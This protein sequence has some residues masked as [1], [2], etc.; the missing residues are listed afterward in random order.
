MYRRDYSDLEDQIIGTVKSA[1]DAIDKIDFV[2]LK[3][4]FTDKTEDTFTEV[5]D[6]FKIYTEKIESKYRE[7]NKRKN[8]DIAKYIMKKP[9]GNVS[10][11]IYIIFGGLGTFI[12]G[13]VSFILLISM[14]FV[15]LIKGVYISFLL[16]S[17]FLLA[18]LI[19][20]FRGM[21]LRKR[22]A[23]FKKYV[24]FMGEK[25]YIKIQELAKLIREKEEFVVKDL[26]KMIDLG[27]FLEGH[28]DDEKTYFMLNDEVYNDY[29]NLKKQMSLKENSEKN[30]EE[31]KVEDQVEN[32]ITIGREYISQIRNIKNSIYRDELSEKLNK[33]ENVAT[34]ILNYVEKNPN[35][36]QDVNKFINHYLPI[37]IKLITSYKELSIQIVQGENIKNAKSEIRKSIDLINTAFE[38]L[39]DDLYEDTVLDISTDI[40]VLKTL[41]KQEGLTEED[42]KK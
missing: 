24:T 11:M 42:F 2:N 6:K 28:I 26:N 31:N 40:S 25:R 34:Q 18:S 9:K 20:L 33:L 23:R 29:L 10:S 15:G 32:I 38:N 37:T 4:E 27:L 16:F 35:K 7:V 21:N 17:I 19:L 13:L 30:K 39:L 41:F 12:F 1:I 14:L 36:K 8:N 22:I 3:R 5:K